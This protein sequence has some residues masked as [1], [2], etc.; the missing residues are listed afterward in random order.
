[1]KMADGDRQDVAS[2]VCSTVC[3]HMPCTPCSQHR[4]HA[5]PN[6]LL[7]HSQSKEELAAA[8]QVA[9]EA[10]VSPPHP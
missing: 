9:L 5:H 3:W 2:M 1:M 7:T 6:P 4:V 10:L 8:L